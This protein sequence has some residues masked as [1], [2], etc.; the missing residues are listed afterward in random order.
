MH[1]EHVHAERV[2]MELW[3]AYDHHAEIRNAVVLASHSNLDNYY[4]HKGRVAV[5]PSFQIQLATR[6][7]CVAKCEE[8]KQNC[9][10]ISEEVI[11]GKCEVVPRGY[12]L[13][14]DYSY[15]FFRKKVDPATVLWEERTNT[16]VPGEIY[17]WYA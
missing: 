16:A 15:D 13:S 2:E 17:E 1:D 11:T 9:A 12:G 14:K 8:M 7:A 6:A 5:G 3:Q 4:H 10:G